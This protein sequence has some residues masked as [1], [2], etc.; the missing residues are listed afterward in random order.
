MMTSVEDFNPS[1]DGDSEKY[2]DAIDSEPNLVDKEAVFIA[3][4]LKQAKDNKK[5]PLLGPEID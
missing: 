4:I 3:R 5:I 1:S 2:F